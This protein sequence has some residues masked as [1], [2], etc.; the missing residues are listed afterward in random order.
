[1]VEMQYK[2]DIF[3][4]YSSPIFI[5]AFDFLKEPGIDHVFE[6]LCF[7]RDLNVDLQFAS[8]GTF[9]ED[10]EMMG[11]GLALPR[12]PFRQG[13]QTVSVATRTSWRTALQC[14]PSNGD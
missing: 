12:F 2:T 14:H 7:L 10:K 3:H 4:S 6:T 11:A 9:L 5:Y 8:H 13:G 1:M